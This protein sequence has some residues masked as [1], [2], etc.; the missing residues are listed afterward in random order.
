MRDG[1]GDDVLDGGDV[2]FGGNGADML[3]GGAGNDTL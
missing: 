1:A 2:F 3:I